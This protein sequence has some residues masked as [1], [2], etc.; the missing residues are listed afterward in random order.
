MRCGASEARSRV[1]SLIQIRLYT[2]RMGA[3]EK[4]HSTDFFTFLHYSFSVYVIS[5]IQ[6]SCKCRGLDAPCSNLLSRP[7]A[8]TRNT[9][10]TLNVSKEGCV[11][12]ILH[13]HVCLSHLHSLVACSVTTNNSPKIQKWGSIQSSTL[14]GRKHLQKDVNV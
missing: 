7:A 6:S 11:L 2:S 10:F 14:P 9:P 1:L 3:R 12:G 13:C 8:C 5:L 4:M